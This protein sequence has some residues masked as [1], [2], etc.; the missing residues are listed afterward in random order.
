MNTKMAGAYI[1]YALQVFYDVHR[2]C[3]IFMIFIKNKKKRV[4]YAVSDDDG[5]PC[6][7][8]LVIHQ[9]CSMPGSMTGRRDRLYCMPADPDS[10]VMTKQLSIALNFFIGAIK[11]L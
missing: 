9:I 2:I 5:V 11:L 7:Q 3:G 10:F 4:E 8:V 6:K 1:A